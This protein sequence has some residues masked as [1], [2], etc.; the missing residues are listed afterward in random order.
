MGFIQGEKPKV[1]EVGIGPPPVV[2]VATPKSRAFGLLA[3][4]SPKPST[5]ESIYRL[6]RVSV[7]VFEIREPASEHRIE[8]FDDVLQAISPSPPGPLPNTILEAGQTLLPDPAPSALEPVTQ[9]LESLAFLH[10][11]SQVGLVRV[12]GQPVGFDPGP[13]P[14][15]RLLAF[16]ATPAQDHE[17]VRITDDAIAG[18]GEV[19]IQWVQIKVRE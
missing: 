1:S 3:Q 12:Q 6:E 11:V 9:E 10:A 16:L 13:Y 15:Q 5:D 14:T 17:V 18:I 7:G 2:R 19:C 8:V 4:D